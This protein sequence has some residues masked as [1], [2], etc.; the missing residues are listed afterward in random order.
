L[1][2]LVYASFFFMQSLVPRTTDSFFFINMYMIALTSTL[3]FL[4][5]CLFSV[6]TAIYLVWPRLLRTR[7]YFQAAIAFT[8]IFAIDVAM[9]YF[10]SGLFHSS[11]YVQ[12]SGIG[13]SGQ[14]GLGYLNSIWAITVMG[15]A[16]AIKLGKVCFV[17]RKENLEIARR[18][19]RTQLDVEKARLR[20]TY[21]YSSLSKIR[22]KTDESFEEPGQMILKLSD[23]LSYTL[24]ESESDLV[25]LQTELAAVIDF[26][27]LEKMKLDGLE[28][29]DLEWD[30]PEDLM[31]P[32]MLILGFLQEAVTQL[33]EHAGSSWSISVRLQ[34]SY[35]RLDLNIAGSSEVGT[36]RFDNASWRMRSRLETVYDSPEFKHVFVQDDHRFSVFVRLNASAI[37]IDQNNKLPA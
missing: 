25:P 33:F 8:G 13:F 14:L 15:L 35:D 12:S 30:T 29:I 32:P 22:Q 26:I 28:L 4:P 10:F 31:V 6:Y 23:V 27:E 19:M 37:F 21:L 20:P 24:Y 5:A 17:Q 7:K 2:W 16:L 11:Y 9:N 1:F 3:C 36:P 34:G 18:S